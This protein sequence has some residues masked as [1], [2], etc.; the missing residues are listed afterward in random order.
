MIW[1]RIVGGTV[2]GLVG[3]PIGVGIGVALGGLLDDDD[4]PTAEASA[5]EVKELV[6]RH[7][8]AHAQGPGVILFVELV[9]RTKRPAAVGLLLRDPARDAFVKAAIPACGDKDGDV[10]LVSAVEIDPATKR[11]QALIFLPYAAVPEMAV[12]ELTARLV[13]VDQEKNALGHEDRK[14]PWLDATLRDEH[15]LL[16]V[17]VDAAVAMVRTA[18]PIERSEVKRIREHLT[19][20]FDL[21]ETGQ[22]VLKRYLKRADGEPR[23]LSTVAE[24][25]AAIVPDAEYG[26]LIDFLYT[27]AAADGCLQAEEEVFI[28]GLAA[29]LSVPAARVAEAREPHAAE[30]LEAHYRVLEL[31]VG[32]TWVEVHKSYLRLAHEYHPDKVGGMARGFQEFANDRMRAIIAAHAVLRQKLA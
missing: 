3:G 18:G 31:P 11:G 5:V 19:A 26:Q 22:G 1:G 16:A 15:N 10:L 27:V 23:D 32:A 6:A 4:A 7:G 12:A 8:Y 24:R 17:L 29:R 21:D 14:L 28:R 25:V 30:D 20:R 13:V 9:E 2:G